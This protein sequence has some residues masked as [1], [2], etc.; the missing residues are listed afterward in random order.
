[1]FD[2][3][4]SPCLRPLHVPR[5][6][7]WLKALHDATPAAHKMRMIGVM[8][9]LAHAVSKGPVPC[10]EAFNEASAYEQIKDAVKGNLVNRHP[11]SHTRHDFG[12]RHGPRFFT[13][14]PEN[15]LTKGGRVQFMA[16]KH[17][18]VVAELAHVYMLIRMQLSCKREKEKGR[19]IF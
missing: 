15:R 16:L 13:H 8:T 17:L 7:V 11:A 3:A 14:G 6:Q 18:F 9:R 10:R 19:A 5:N 12:R 1:M 2:K 4:F